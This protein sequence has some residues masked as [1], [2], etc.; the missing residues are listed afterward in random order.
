MVEWEP[1]GVTEAEVQRMKEDRL[2]LEVAL[3]VGWRPPVVRALV[4]V[5]DD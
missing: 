4:L 1:S 5:P 3:A 2:A